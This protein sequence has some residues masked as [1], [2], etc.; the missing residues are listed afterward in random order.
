MRSRWR[1]RTKNE[2][3]LL[4]FL[5]LY[6]IPLLWLIYELDHGEI[7][8]FPALFLNFSLDLDHLGTFM[9]GSTEIIFELLKL[10]CFQKLQVEHHYTLPT[11]ET[12]SAK[13]SQAR[14]L[15][16]MAMDS[17]PTYLMATC[18]GIDRAHSTSGDDGS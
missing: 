4:L 11:M 10:G 3:F 17:L 8:L 18:H 15:L 9:C 6:C 12:E 13:H 5:S 14:R 7:N 1:D 2:L 16:H